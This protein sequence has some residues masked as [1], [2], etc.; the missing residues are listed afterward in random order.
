[1]GYCEEKKERLMDLAL[2]EVFG[3]DQ[4]EL[5]AHLAVCAGCRKR[6]EEDRALVGMLKSVEM[7]EPSQKYLE[8]LSEKVFHE[9]LA[10]RQAPKKAVPEVSRMANWQ[11]ALH[12]RIKM[13]AVAAALMLLLFGKLAMK[14]DGPGMLPP[15]GAA[16]ISKVVEQ[17]P[18]EMSAIQ[19]YSDT[20]DDS[21]DYE[22]EEMFMGEDAEQL[23]ELDWSGE[24]IAGDSYDMYDYLENITEEEAEDLLKMLENGGELQS[25][26]TAG[27][28]E[29]E[30]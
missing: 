17:Y 29:M 7:V 20:R 27:K 23:A 30:V 19:E 8:G 18:L 16:S 26:I 12:G 22:L 14:V 10:S 2:G 3:A 28:D 11:P 24:D 6:V 25:G 4:V 9:V 1:M 5:E 21:E 13:V 15:G